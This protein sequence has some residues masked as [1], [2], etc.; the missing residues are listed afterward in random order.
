MVKGHAKQGK[1]LSVSNIVEGHRRR[2]VKAP[3]RFTSEVNFHS[4]QREN[5]TC[6]SVARKAVKRFYAQYKEERVERQVTDTVVVTDKLVPNI[7]QRFLDFCHPK[8]V[9]RHYVW[10]GRNM[11]LYVRKKDVTYVRTWYKRKTLPGHMK[12]FSAKDR[13]EQLKLIEKKILL[14]KENLKTPDLHYPG[15]LRGDAEAEVKALVR[16]RKRVVENQPMQECLD[17]ILQRHGCKL[18]SRINLSTYRKKGQDGEVTVECFNELAQLCLA[19]VVLIEFLP[20]YQT[21]TDME[22]EAPT[23]QL[24]P[25]NEEWKHAKDDVQ[26]LFE[27]FL[28][29]VG[30]MESNDETQ[31]SAA[32]KLQSEL[33][34]QLK[35]RGF[36]HMYESEDVD[37]DLYT[38]TQIQ[39]LQNILVPLSNRLKTEYRKIQAPKAPVVVKTPPPPVETEAERRRKAEERYQRQLQKVK[40]CEALGKRCR[41]AIRPV[42]QTTREERMDKRD[43]MR[44]EEQVKARKRQKKEE[45]AN[46]TSEELLEDFFIS[47]DDSDESDDDSD[48]AA[49]HVVKPNRPFVFPTTAEKS[50]EEAFRVF[51]PDPSSP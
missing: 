16:Y 1:G 41:P 40:A 20:E 13:A 23:K 3:T 19:R 36:G 7:K 25:D 50:V 31:R 48:P 15:T 22:A 38:F 4:S 9:N 30:E 17:E 24:V 45:A 44:F 21:I 28:K 39:A 12:P 18:D 51:C 11:C 37:L 14:L 43:T 33:E 34:D 26:R 27:D 47:E 10:K 32:V 8:R 49:C 42:Y 5:R 35:A 6:D 2:N 46:K 29:L